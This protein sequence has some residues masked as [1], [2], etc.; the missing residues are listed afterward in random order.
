MSY[1]KERLKYLKK[2]KTGK[3]PPPRKGREKKNTP[4]EKEKEEELL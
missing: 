1:S 3:I 4:L 2:R